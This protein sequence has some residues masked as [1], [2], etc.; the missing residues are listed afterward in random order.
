MSTP[1]SCGDAHLNTTQI[2]T[3]QQRM[4]LRLDTGDVMIVHKRLDYLLLRW[5]SSRQSTVQIQLVSML[6]ARNITLPLTRMHKQLHIYIIEKRM[7][8]LQPTTHV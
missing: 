2:T 1:L 5:R 6:H 7:A 3:L 4:R 8:T